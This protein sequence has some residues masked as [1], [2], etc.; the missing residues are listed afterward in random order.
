MIYQ[1]TEVSTNGDAVDFA[2]LKKKKL[3]ILRETETGREGART[4]SRLCSVDTE[5]DIWLEIRNREFMT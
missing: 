2:D 5:P 1:K 4:P 3:F